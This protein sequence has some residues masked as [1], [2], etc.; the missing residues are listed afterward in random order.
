MQE[1]ILLRYFFLLLDNNIPFDI[2]IVDYKQRK[3]AIKEINYA[4]NLAKIYN[5]KCFL[6]SYSYDKFSE[7]KARDFRY[8]FFDDIILLNSY[9]SLIT[10]HQLNDKVEW[11]FM[12]FSKGAGLNELIG[13]EHISHRKNYIVHKPLL[14]ISKD[15]LLTYLELK[16]IKYFIDET[17]MDNK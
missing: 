17:N 11:F 6:S 10:A 1:L 13:L 8:K 4:K 7:K 9:D 2:A 5:K 12:Q 14:D 15:E 3:Q 16:N